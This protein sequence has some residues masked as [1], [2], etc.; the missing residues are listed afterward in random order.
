MRS[1]IVL[2]AVLFGLAFGVLFLWKNQSG[3]EYLLAQYQKIAPFSAHEMTYHS[4]SKTAIGNGLTFY[5]PQFPRLPLRFKSDRLQMEATPLE[6]RLHFSN[7][8]IDMAQTLTLRDGM[9]LVDTLKSFSPPTSFVTQPLETFVLLNRDV[10][11]GTMDLVIKPEGYQTRLIATLYQKGKETLRFT[12]VIQG[13][14][15]KE[16]WGWT[17]GTFDFAQ[18]TVSDL[19]FIR[20]IT[21]YYRATNR[22]IPQDLQRSAQSGTPFETV[23]RLN[24][25]MPVM[26]LLKRF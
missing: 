23:I 13:A 21:D 14:T 17:R 26:G 7:M 24:A 18:L 6:I 3:T 25:P 2:F 1:F 10:F 19:S 12:T 5:R 22:P 20:A 15:G 9:D 8:T 16:L 11:K 4:V